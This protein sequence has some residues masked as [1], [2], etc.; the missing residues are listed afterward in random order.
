MSGLS[1]NKFYRGKEVLSSL[2]F[3]MKTNIINNLISLT[4]PY[5]LSPRFWPAPKNR[6]I[7]CSHPGSSGSRSFSVLFSMFSLPQARNCRNWWIS[8]WTIKPTKDC[9]KFWYLSNRVSGFRWVF[10]G[11]LF[12]L[13]VFLVPCFENIAINC[14]R[15][16]RSSL[17]VEYDWRYMEFQVSSHPS[18]T[19][20]RFKLIAYDRMPDTINR[21]RIIFESTAVSP[22][23]II[24]DLII[25]ISLAKESFLQQIRNFYLLLVC[26]DCG[27]TNVNGKSDDGIGF[28]IIQKSLMYRRFRRSITNDNNECVGQNMIVNCCLQK[29]TVDKAIIF[30]NSS[31]I[32]APNTIP[33]TY[34]R[35]SC[36]CEW[37]VFLYLADDILYCSSGHVWRQSQFC[38]AEILPFFERH[39]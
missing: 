26:I 28:L 10:V 2:I 12:Y 24:M 21:D 23:P 20:H 38:S 30:E 8:N 22:D 36:Y 17:S 9:Q 16:K 11:F 7:T 33:V 37:L 19:E 35:G 5:K 29:I 13:L 6:K 31:K 34:C 15:I 39:C 25:D 4:I 18:A 32:V 3:H 14:F 1:V 27:Q